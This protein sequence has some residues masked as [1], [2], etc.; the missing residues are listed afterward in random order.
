MN[1][2]PSAMNPHPL[3]DKALRLLHLGDS[4]TIGEGVAM[5]SNWPN[6]LMR[7][8]QSFG[9]R[10]E[11]SRIIAQTGWTTGDLLQA[12]TKADL[13]SNWDL[14]TL[15]IGVNNQYQGLPIDEY[16]KEY[17]PMLTVSTTLRIKPLIPA[18]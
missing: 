11:D 3:P 9:Y 5:D 10:I 16:Q 7:S 15:C 2:P 1:T 18:M 14:V 17:N 8:L 13:Q 4:Y 6:C 12:L